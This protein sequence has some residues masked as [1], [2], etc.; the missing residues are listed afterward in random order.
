[1][2]HAATVKAISVMQASLEGKTI[3]A[4]NEHN[5]WEDCPADS[6]P[7]WHWATTAYR[8]KPS[9][10]RTRWIV[11][12]G[13]GNETLYFHD[14]SQGLAVL[15]TAAKFVEVMEDEAKPIQPPPPPPPPPRTGPL[16]IGDRVKFIGNLKDVPVGTLATVTAANPN[17]PTVGVEFDGGK[18]HKGFTVW[19]TSLER[20]TDP[21]WTHEFDVGD[22]GFTVGGWGYQVMYKDNV[23]TSDGGKRLIQVLHDHDRGLWWH[24]IDGKHGRKLGFDLL[25]PPPKAGL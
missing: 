15:E 21:Q 23:A 5:Q 10:P 2:N 14:P 16:V 8:V 22:S 9:G 7:A 4:L 20:V 12:D 1:M 25:P 24:A 18:R 11:T 13:V 6:S 17:D 3:Q 19:R